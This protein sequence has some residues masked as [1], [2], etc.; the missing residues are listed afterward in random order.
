MK[1]IYKE[2][3]HT[4]W[5]DYVSNKEEIRTGQQEFVATLQLFHSC[6]YLF[7]EKYEKMKKKGTSMCFV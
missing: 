2:E 6:L 3:T 5:K 4:E 7:R 1:Y